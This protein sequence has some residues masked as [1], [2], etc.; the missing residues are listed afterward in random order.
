[1]TGSKILV[2]DDQ[3]R[4]F[5]LIQK[6]LQSEFE[7]DLVDGPA[8]AWACLTEDPD[9]A[10]IVSDLHMPLVDGVKFL[11]TVKNRYPSITRIIMTADGDQDAAVN[12]VNEGEVFR[13][14]Q[15]PVSI[16]GL[17]A[18]MHAG[19]ANHRSLDVE[20]NVLEETL[21]GSIQL[22]ID[23]LK[24]LRPLAFDRSRRIKRLV[25]A[26]CAELGVPD[27][28]DLQAAAML[29]Q[30]GCLSLPEDLLKS[31]FAGKNVGATKEMQFNQHVTFGES[32]IE[33]IPRMEAIRRL[34]SWQRKHFDE[35]RLLATSERDLT[36]ASILSA[37]LAYDRKVMS[38][39]SPEDA[40]E[41]M[42]R[43]PKQFQGRMV[44]ALATIVISAKT[45]KEL[46]VWEL[47]DGMEL[48][49]DLSDQ[50]GSLLVP[51]GRTLTH[52][53]IQK[54]QRRGATIEEPIVVTVAEPQ[55]DRANSAE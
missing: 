55:F 18:V 50:H 38:G 49:S 21:E 42:Q 23:L 33:N 12:A 52:D 5:E 3:P 16:D 1:M 13:F 17:R 43:S 35:L 44:E 15:K 28:W 10:V 34:V 29:S 22:L 46:G 6:S 51:R 4:S 27:R 2:V 31:I 39:D 36:A 9:Y 11:A 8:K 40:I 48:K 54:L 47:R 26:V 25:S 7:I 24:K 30:I 53:T 41:E 14:L 45:I 37:C 19:L 32:L 20:T